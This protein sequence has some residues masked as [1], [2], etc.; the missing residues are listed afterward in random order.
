MVGS[1]DL[2]FLPSFMG[3]QKQAGER[4]RKTK[5]VVSTRVKKAA[6]Y[7]SAFVPTFYPAGVAR[8]SLNFVELN[9]IELSAS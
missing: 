3:R 7:R 5:R 9:R 8:K 4:A 2:R 6:E 1:R